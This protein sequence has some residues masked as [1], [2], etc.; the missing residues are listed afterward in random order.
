M[1]MGI[2][3]VVKFG[4]VTFSYVSQKS[5]SQPRYGINAGHCETIWN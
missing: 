1:N 4:Q 5:H 3:K 2:H